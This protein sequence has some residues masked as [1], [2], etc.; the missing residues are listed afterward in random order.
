MPFEYAVK[1]I[2]KDYQQRK[3]QNF[4]S[5]KK[6]PDNVSRLLHFLATNDVLTT[7]QYD[8]LLRYLSEQKSHQ[9]KLEIGETADDLMDQPAERSNLDLQRK[10]K[11]ILNRR[12]VTEMSASSSTGS[13]TAINYEAIKASLLSNHRVQQALKTLQS[14]K[15][16]Q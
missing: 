2:Y 13:S 10:I 9:S 14:S 3:K 1:F 6:H 16:R 5:G 8:L 4:T 7:S 11:E 12:P 15:T